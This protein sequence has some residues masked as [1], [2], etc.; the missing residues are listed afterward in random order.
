MSDE[1][2]FTDCAVEATKALAKEI[3]DDV[4][5]PVLRPAGQLLGLPF[6]GILALFS[7]FQ[8]W[9]K[10]R[11]YKVAETVKLLEEK[12]SNTPQDQI[13]APEPY[14]AVPAIQYISYCMDNEELRNMY[15]NLLASSMNK[16]VKNGV[17]PSFVE[18]IKQLCPDEAKILRYL[19]ENHFVATIAI[20]KMD[21]PFTCSVVFNNFSDVGY[22][23]NCEM[24]SDI[25]KYFNNL[26]RLGL[27]N[28]GPYASPLSDD[29]YYTSLLSHDYIKKLKNDI[30]SK[31]RNVTI[32]AE[33]SFIE[34]TPFGKAFCS[35]CLDSYVNN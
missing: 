23:T 14:I 25:N 18:I 6:S 30:I 24:P 26:E 5:K 33:K 22:K 16:A 21:A 10:D 9:I 32:E 3:Y 34:I 20:T 8:C 4:A 19:Y 11:E 7:G 31:E 17:H 35:V 12:L 2:L 15:A 13:E 29:S 27:V 1:K 28:D